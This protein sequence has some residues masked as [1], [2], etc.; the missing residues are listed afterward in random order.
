MR[1]WISLQ[2]EF[3]NFHQRATIFVFAIKMSFLSVILSAVV[4]AVALPLLQFFGLLP[5]PLMAAIQFGVILSWLIGVVV[6]GALAVFAGYAIHEL[7]VSRAEFERLSR[8]DML[9]GLLNRRAFTE[10][11]ERIEGDASLVIFDVDRF[12][13]I[14][15][16]YGHASGDAVIVAVSRIFASIFNGESLVARLGGEEFGAILRGGTLSERIEHIERARVMIAREAIPVEGGEARITISA[17]IADMSSGRKKE[18]VYSAADKAL[19]LAKALGRNRMVHESETLH[20]GWHPRAV[21]GISERQTS[22]NDYEWQQY[23]HG[24]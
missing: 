8:T 3:G 2:A 10:A 21:E 6:C 17:G 20:H 24:I 5:L 1:K 12:K 23:G 19:Y 11:L 4:I 7:S 13:A 18:A 15:D 14:N 22:P 9:S 16:R